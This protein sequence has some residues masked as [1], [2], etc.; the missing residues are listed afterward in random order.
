MPIRIVLA[1]ATNSSGEWQAPHHGTPIPNALENSALVCL[2]KVYGAENPRMKLYMYIGWPA[3]AFT[4]C[5]GYSGSKTIQ[6]VN[7]WSKV[8]HP[9]D[10]GG[11]R[12][13][14]IHR[15]TLPLTVRGRVH[16][17]VVG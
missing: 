3:R 15:R 13:T 12:T 10:G 17:P 9:T 5:I 4:Y 1:I 7:K 11:D 2:V 8:S 14:P 6:C 16:L